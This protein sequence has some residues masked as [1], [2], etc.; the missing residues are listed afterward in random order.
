[1]S[2]VAFFYA[3]GLFLTKSPVA[4]ALSDVVRYHQRNRS[5]YSAEGAEGFHGSG[6]H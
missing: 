3:R 4:L 5:A 2:G 1:M 6:D